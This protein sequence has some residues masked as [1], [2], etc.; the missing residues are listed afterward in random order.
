MA[1]SQFLH[2]IEKDIDNK[3]V[4]PVNKILRQAAKEGFDSVTTLQ[5]N[6]GRVPINTGYFRSNWK[7]TLN[8]PSESVG[9]EPNDSQR[10]DTS[11]YAPDQYASEFARS[12]AYA[13]RSMAVYSIKSHKGFYL[14]NHTRYGDIIEAN[15]GLMS[16][17]RQRIEHA[18]QQINSI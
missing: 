11:M 5:R 14:T 12:K 4:N 8:A 16:Y 15:W 1:N 2:D 17:A 18:L 13:N 10:P 9:I 3:I 7:L 6:G